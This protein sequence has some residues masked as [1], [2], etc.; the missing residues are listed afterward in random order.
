MNPYDE[1]PSW[2]QLLDPWIGPPWY[3]EIEDFDA[4]LV[5]V[6]EQLV[7]RADELTDELTRMTDQA[8]GTLARAERLTPTRPRVEQIIGGDAVG[9]RDWPASVRPGDSG[10]SRVAG[11]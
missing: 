9:C 6:R 10:L 7:R 1:L 3:A 8:R 4:W 11:R 5:A 2:C